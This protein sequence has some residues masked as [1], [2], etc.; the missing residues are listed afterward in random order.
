MKIFVLNGSPKREH[1][2]TMKIIPARRRTSVL[3]F[4]YY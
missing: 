3:C 2:D 1:N 4:V